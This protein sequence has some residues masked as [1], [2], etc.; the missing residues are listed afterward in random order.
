MGDK[1]GYEIRRT[2]SK[3]YDSILEFMRKNFFKDEPLNIAVRL[4][5]DTDTCPELEQFCTET[6]ADGKYR[7]NRLNVYS[8]Y[9]A[10]YPVHQFHLL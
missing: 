4:L 6:L 1:S 8:I 5:E 3:D 2:T 9:H 10:G 7:D